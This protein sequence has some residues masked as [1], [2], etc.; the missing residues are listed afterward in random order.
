MQWFGVRPR[1]ATRRVGGDDH[2]WRDVVP[3]GRIRA[4]YALAFDAKAAIAF[5]ARRDRRTGGPIKHLAPTLTEV[6]SRSFEASTAWGR[7]E[8]TI[9]TE[10]F[11][12]DVQSTRAA[13]ARVLT[14]GG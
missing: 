3:I 11:G 5:P 6:A 8:I 13:S 4:H 10:R 9:E 1:V 2:G 12:A 14:V 7:L